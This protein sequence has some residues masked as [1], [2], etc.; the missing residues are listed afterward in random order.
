MK[1]KTIIMLLLAAFLSVSC[2]DDPSEWSKETKEL[3]D[4]YNRVVVGDW[5]Y[6]ESNTTKKESAQISLHEDGT[7]TYQWKYSTRNIVTVNGSPVLTDWE[8]LF[9]ERHTGRWELIHDQAYDIDVIR[10]KTKDVTNQDKVV[11]DVHDLEFEYA[12]TEFL[13]LQA[14]WGYGKIVCFERGTTE[15]DFMKK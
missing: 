6:E 11:E 7:M 12:N 9:N 5:F 14:Y 15:W 10:L 3:Q 2:D 4:K 8:P 1:A 13:F